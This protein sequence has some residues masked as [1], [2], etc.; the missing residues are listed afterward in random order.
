LGAGAAAPLAAGA[1][2]DAG[3]DAKTPAATA[4]APRNSLLFMDAPPGLR[5]IL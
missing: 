3:T 4:A 2:L 1:W 5:H